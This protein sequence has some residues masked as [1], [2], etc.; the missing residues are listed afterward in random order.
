MAV[1]TVIP[2][3]LSGGSGTRLWPLSRESFPKQYLRLNKFDEK[4]LLQ[5][6]YE[7]IRKLTNLS[8]P[9]LICNEDHRFIVAEQ[10]REIE[11]EPQA[12]LLEPFGRNT[13][14]AITLAAMKALEK[15]DDPT[16]L[17]LS[18]DHKILD[19][20]KFLAVLEKGMEYAKEEKLVTFGV[21]PTNPETGYG[22]IEASSPFSDKVLGKKIER[23]TEK[24]NKETALKFLKNKSFTWNSGIFMFKAKII[25]E[26]I[27]RFSPEIYNS[28]KDS[29]CKSNL[30]LDFQR[31]DKNCFSNC[32][33]FSIDI[34]VMEKTNK[35]IVL[36]LKAGWSDIGSWQAL[37][38]ISEKDC[39]NNFVK[40]NV[41]LD[42]TKNSYLRSENRLIVGIGLDNLVVIETNDAI[43]ILDKNHSEKVKGIVK[44]LKDKSIPEGQ[45][46]SKIFRPWGYYETLVSDERWQVKLIKVKPKEKLSL[47]MHHHRSEHWVV[48]KGKAKIELDKKIKFLNKNESIYIPLGSKHRLINAGKTPLTL[49]EIQSGSYIAED[50]IVRFEDKYGRV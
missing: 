21:I 50:D 39:D 5:L 3:I 15:D 9:I 17:V 22:Y 38:E 43:L 40:G 33:N 31:I 27:K 23:F 20:K 25:I 48:V 49:I 29:I 19:E 1:N 30:D 26:E 44:K 18:S 12:I 35:G 10:M 6:T 8:N 24:P 13:A 46:H 16:L 7:R 28:C 34:A 14:P 41:V 37:W 36:P 42:E 47:Q 4:S 11:V 2:V 32:P 45:K